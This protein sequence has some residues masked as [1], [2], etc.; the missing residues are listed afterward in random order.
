MLTTYLHIFASFAFAFHVAVFV[1]I[2]LGWGAVGSGKFESLPCCCRTMFDTVTSL[3]WFACWLV[4][5]ACV[6]V[7]CLSCVL[8]AIS[9]LMDNVLCP[10]VEALGSKLQ[11]KLTNKLSMFGDSNV[12]DD[13]VKG[14]IGPY[15]DAM[16]DVQAGL[17]HLLGGVVV[18]FLTSLQFSYCL[19]WLLKHCIIMIYNSGD[20]K[21]AQDKLHDKL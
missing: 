4:T 2:F 18:L 19:L 8:F 20:G 12:D 15:C 21:Y 5:I 7:L 10:E 14:A 13:A 9:M 17:K 3:L 11:K 1:V 6:V 16:D